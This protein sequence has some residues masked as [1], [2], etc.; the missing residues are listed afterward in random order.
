MLPENKVGMGGGGTTAQ[1]YPKV[2]GYDGK[3]SLH[4]TQ[5][6]ANGRKIL[7][8]HFLMSYFHLTGEYF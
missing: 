5:I 7:T 3:M 1:S 6:L 4:L 8:L 2:A